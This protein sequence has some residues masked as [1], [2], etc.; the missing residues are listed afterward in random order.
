MNRVG[1]FW[2]YELCSPS[3][4]PGYVVAEC[5]RATCGVYGS[6]TQFRAYLELSAPPPAGS[7]QLANTELNPNGPCPPTSPKTLSLRSELQSSGVS[8]IDCPHNS[9]KNVADS[10]LACDLVCFALDNPTSQIPYANHLPV[11]SYSI[12][13][14][15]FSAICPTSIPTSKTTIVLISGDRDF[16]YPLAVLKARKYEVGLI[17]PPG[18]AHPAL[19]AKQPGPNSGVTPPSQGARRSFVP[20]R[21]SI[22]GSRR[23][24]VSISPI[25]VP[26][27]PHLST[28]IGSSAASN[29]FGGLGA[30]EGASNS[31]ISNN[32]LLRA[33]PQASCFQRPGHLESHLRRPAAKAA[34]RPPSRSKSRIGARTGNLERTE[35]EARAGPSLAG[36]SPRAGRPQTPPLFSTNPASP[37]PQPPLQRFLRLLHPH[38]NLYTP[39]QAIHSTERCTTPS[40][41]A[42]YSTRGHTSS[43]NPRTVPTGCTRHFKPQRTACRRNGT[44]TLV[45]PTPKP[46]TNVLQSLLPAAAVL[47]PVVSS[48][49]RPALAVPPS[50][51]TSN[52]S[53]LA[54]ATPVTPLLLHHLGGR[55]SNR[56]MTIPTATWT[57]LPLTRRSRRQERK[58]QGEGT[59][60]QCGQRNPPARKFKRRCNEEPSAVS[61]V[62][63]ILRSYTERSPRVERDNQ[64]HHSLGDGCSSSE[65]PVGQKGGAHAPLD[66][67]VDDDDEEEEQFHET[68]LATFSRPVCSNAPRTPATVKLVSLELTSEENCEGAVEHKKP[69]VT[70]PRPIARTSH[71]LPLIPM[72]QSLLAGDTQARNGCRSWRSSPI[73]I[74]QSQFSY[75]DRSPGSSKAEN[76]PSAISEDF[77]DGAFDPLL[78]ATYREFQFLISVLERCRR[79]GQERPLRSLIGAEFT[80]DVFEQAKATSFKDHVQRAV[81]AGVVSVGDGPVQGREW[82]SLNGNWKGFGL[83]LD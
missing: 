52:T 8:L 66:S 71:S 26:P 23:G 32:S 41:P 65:D 4:T 48:P 82:I 15:P 36:M 61:G 73:F 29:S 81:A 5:V 12:P 53:T 75:T 76:N 17:V 7:S 20:R 40:S 78:S 44:A 45:V 80:R 21:G 16:A 24:S 25:P 46:S 10:M 62:D 83:V 38:Q 51:Q 67:T 79:T 28:T 14:T 18:G 50:I 72:M 27:P 13:N 9:R 2:D 37:P 6:V 70:T 74:Q 33:F 39:S 35:Q 19:R 43:A 30:H 57:D 11:S 55:G 31:F 68:F 63:S 69:R 3:G 34:A 54:P 58:V 49:T 60:S 77:S 64:N 1:I 59:P 47:R 42:V 22:S 56:S